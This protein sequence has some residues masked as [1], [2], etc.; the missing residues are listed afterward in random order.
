MSMSVIPMFTVRRTLAPG[1]VP[2]YLAHLDSLHLVAM[3]YLNVCIYAAAHASVELLAPCVHAHMSTSR[4]LDVNLLDG[5]RPSRW[6]GLDNLGHFFLRLPPL[7]PCMRFAGYLSLGP[8]SASTVACTPLLRSDEVSDSSHL[9]RPSDLRLARPTVHALLLTRRPR[10]IGHLSF[11][12]SQSLS[13]FLA[14]SM[15][16]LPNKTSTEEASRVTASR[17]PHEV[18]VCPS[19]GGESRCS[20]ALMRPHRLK[21]S[22]GAHRAGVTRRESNAAPKTRR[23]EGISGPLAPG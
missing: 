4:R 7:L 3:V 13:V 10:A 23:L 11:C 21:I 1:V 9:V 14:G 8:E 2:T 12:F 22:S 19:A 20:I 6:S 18:C 17:G 16:Q 15:I 5:P